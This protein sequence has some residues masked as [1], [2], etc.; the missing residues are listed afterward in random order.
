L[1]ND[2]DKSDAYK[3]AAVSY[4]GT[5]VA[6]FCSCTGTLFIPTAE[7]PVFYTREPKIPDEFLCSLFC[8]FHLLSF[9]MCYSS[10]TDPET[11]HKYSLIQ[12]K[13]F[14]SEGFE[15]LTAVVMKRY[16]F[17]DITPCNEAASSGL[18]LG[19]FFDPEDEG[20][21]SSETSIDFHRTIERYIPDDRTLHL[22]SI[23][24][25]FFQLIKCLF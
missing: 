3:L 13:F 4:H 20:A 24:S 17:W 8:F 15:V 25:S 6:T 22:S 2:N 19:L 5:E 9:H 18:Y 7:D 23:L 11:S 14:F 21:C 10:R 12:I 16:I 1:R